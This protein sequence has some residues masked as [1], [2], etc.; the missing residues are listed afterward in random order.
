MN[1]EEIDALAGQVIADSTFVQVMV[2]SLMELI[3]Q[4]DTRVLAKE[5]V[6]D[7]AQRASIA[8]QHLCSYQERLQ[9]M[10]T[11]VLEARLPPSGTPPIGM[12]L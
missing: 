4:F 7:L 3:P 2:I 5:A 6:V 1:K 10:R 9:E 12:G 8:P 11:F